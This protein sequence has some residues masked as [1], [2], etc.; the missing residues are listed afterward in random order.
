MRRNSLVL[1]AHRVFG[2]ISNEFVS[3]LILLA[4]LIEH[5]G[6]GEWAIAA[7]TSLL[8][9]GGITQIVAAWWIQDGIR[10]RVWLL[11]VTGLSGGLLLVLA[12]AIALLGGTSPALLL[13]L[14]LL[15]I[16]L[17]ALAE[18]AS[19]PALLDLER[20]LIDPPDR[21]RVF[22]CRGLLS[23]ASGLLAGLA[24]GA[25]LG[26]LGF[27]MGYAVVMALGA[28]AT[29]AAWTCILGLQEGSALPGRDDPATEIPPS[30]APRRP[31]PLD[32]LRTLFRL[33]TPGTD[34]Q[35]RTFRRY[36]L[37]RHLVFLS[38]CAFPFMT[39]Y[40]IRRHQLA[41]GDAAAFVVALNAG[42]LAGG[43]LLSAVPRM[44][45]TAGRV[46]AL[47]MGCVM[48]SLV[49]AVLGA[50]WEFILGAFFL[51]G[52]FFEALL[53][54]DPLYMMAHTPKGHEMTGMALTMVAL[55]PLGILLPQ[56]SGLIYDRCG[57]AVL[58]GVGIAAAALAIPALL[59]L[60]DPRREIPGRGGE[61]R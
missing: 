15:L 11:G 22:A 13:G 2:G 49:L 37:V 24:A 32:Y 59:L 6:G 29:A 27:P 3:P 48:G 36:I 28:A 38:R 18:P 55:M 39:L 25:V 42:R 31:A 7:L 50:Q 33:L 35:G 43:A 14:V 16:G 17:R 10:R 47:A 51:Q 45:R 58:A 21:A 61:A 56:A 1:I 54:A 9:F 52:L 57:F 12:A 44:R 40:A 30:P 53:V 20:T 19:W 23:A 5:L 4:A 34:D 41:P 8:T 60:R 46:M 26:A